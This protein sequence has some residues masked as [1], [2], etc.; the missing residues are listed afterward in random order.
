MAVM[1]VELPSGYS[2]DV[3]AL[4]AA[5]RAKEVKRVDT[6]NHDGTVIIYLDRVTRDELCL[7][8]PAHRTHRVANNK[9]VPVTIYDYYDR[10]RTSRIFY[11]PTLVTVSELANQPDTVSKHDAAT[12][13]DDDESNDP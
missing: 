8:V 7:T 2:A 6:A 13:N 12:D 1:E 9:P 11:E 4:P 5:T 3:E 10:S